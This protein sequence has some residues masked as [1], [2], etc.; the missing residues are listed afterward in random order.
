ML[1]YAT[2]WVLS[3]LFIFWLALIICPL[4]LIRLKVRAARL[5]LLALET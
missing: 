2:E 3:P 5:V 1:F 4:L